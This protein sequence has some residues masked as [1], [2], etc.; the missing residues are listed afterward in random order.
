MSIAIQD[1]TENR[2]SAGVESKVVASDALIAAEPALGKRPDSA[3]RV[4]EPIRKFR[5]CRFTVGMLSTAGGAALILG[6]GFFVDEI[7]DAGGEFTLPLVGI[8]ALVGVML[9]GGGF[10]VMATSSSGFDE[11]EFDRL[12]TAGNISAVPVRECTITTVAE[13]NDRL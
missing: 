2:V 8:L 11:E 12:A 1:N 13:Q 9:L 10:G 6:V 4:Q 7:R 5:A 3:S